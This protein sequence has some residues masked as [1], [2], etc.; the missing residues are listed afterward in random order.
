MGV[1]TFFAPPDRARPAAIQ[2]QHQKLSEAPALSSVLSSVPEFVAVLNKERQV[3]Y[4]NTALVRFLN[5]DSSLPLCG[6]RPGELFNCIH[7]AEME[8]GCGTSAGCRDCSAVQAILETQSSNAS[9][10]RECV[11]LGI[12]L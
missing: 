1:K 10:S 7:S 9:K 8:H 2:R 5:A 4:A 6:L 12:D 11:L 3:V